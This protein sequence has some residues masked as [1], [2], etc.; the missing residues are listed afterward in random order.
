MLIDENVKIA[1]NTEVG[2]F[3]LL[4]SIEGTS[5]MIVGLNTQLSFS[6]VQDKR[7]S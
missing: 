6:V 4:Q 2:K 3:I 7:K 5:N 1:E